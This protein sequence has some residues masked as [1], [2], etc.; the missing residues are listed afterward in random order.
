ML[1]FTGT[2]AGIMLPALAIVLLEAF[3]CLHKTITNCRDIGRRVPQNQGF[4]KARPDIVVEKK[5]DSLEEDK[6]LADSKA[7]IPVLKAVCTVKQ[8]FFCRG[9]VWCLVLRPRGL[10]WGVTFLSRRT[11]SKVNNRL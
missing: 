3:S 7:L 8:C 6:S 11:F 2:L 9:F 1:L 10:L 4:L 5:S